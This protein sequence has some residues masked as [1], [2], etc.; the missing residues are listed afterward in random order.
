[1][2]KKSIEN[3]DRFYVYIL[4]DPRKPGKFSYRE[5]DILFDFEPFYVG[6]GTG[7]QINC[8]DAE[9]HSNTRTRKANKIRK[10]YE[11]T[12]QSHI[13]IKLFENLYEDVSFSLE[14]FLIKL[15][16][17]LDHQRG[18]LTNGTDGGDGAS[19]KIVSKETRKKISEGLSGEKHPLCGKHHTEETKKKMS[20]AHTG[21][22]LSEE[23]KNKLSEIH[24]GK[25]LSKDHKRKLSEVQSGKHHSEETKKRMSKSLIGEKNSFY[26]KHHSEEVRKKIAD[27]HSGKKQSEETKQKIREYW[28]RRKERI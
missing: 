24:S 16:G 12:G 6:K 26:G 25:I 2:T 22:I 11:E 21:K 17:R 18:S 4:L 13:K 28:I 14:I 7:N 1:M 23:T 20:E 5:S 9:I 19:G 10:I 15:I 3:E 27:A 8:H